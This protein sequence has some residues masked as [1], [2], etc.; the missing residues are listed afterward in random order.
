[1]IKPG[2]NSAGSVSF[3]S[4]D[5]AV[6]P[7]KSS[8]SLASAL[9]SALSIAAAQAACSGSPDSAAKDF[10]LS[11]HSSPACV[12]EVIEPKTATVRQINNVF[13]L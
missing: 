7:R 3:A 9:T 13:S 4:K 5:D 8:H 2:F 1:M 6:Y 10:Q 11:I 12:V